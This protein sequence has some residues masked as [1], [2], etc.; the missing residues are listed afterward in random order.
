[1]TQIMAVAIIC[2]GTILQHDLRANLDF[3]MIDLGYL[4]SGALTVGIGMLNWYLFEALYSYIPVWSILIRPMLILSCILYLYDNAPLP[5]RDIGRLNPVI[6]LVDLLRAG[7]YAT[8]KAPYASIANV[9][10][11][12]CILFALGLAMLNLHPWVA[13]N[14]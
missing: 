10:G 13:V 2:T 12:G 4:V 11:L 8:C 14:R 5:L 3:S 1:M 9:M 7:S 6:L